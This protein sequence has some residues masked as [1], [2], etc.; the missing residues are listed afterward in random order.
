MTKKQLEH[1]SPPEKRVAAKKLV[2]AGYSIRTIEDL[3]GASNASISRW[4]RESTPD[5]MKQF[6]A[7][8]NKELKAWKKQGLGM[9]HK[10]LLEL[11]PR[12]RRIDQ[13]V[14]AGEYLDGSNRGKA[15]RVESKDMKVEFL[16]FE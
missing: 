16:E 1:L 15:V 8:F 6:E 3:I 5:E 10:R 2:E 11:L 14:K 9:V 4:A 12:E 7:D 13:V